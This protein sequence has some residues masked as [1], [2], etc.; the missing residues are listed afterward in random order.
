MIPVWITYNSAGTLWSRG[1]KECYVWFMKP[2]YYYQEYHH[3]QEISPWSDAHKERGLRYVGWEATGNGDNDPGSFSFGKVFGYSDGDDINQNFIAAYVWAR[4]EEHFQHAPFG[5][6]WDKLERERKVLAKD[7]LL[8]LNL[9]V[10]M[11]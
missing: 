6:E 4:L 9:K 2:E 5:R 3:G 11:L 10:T 7:F 8:Q 1:L